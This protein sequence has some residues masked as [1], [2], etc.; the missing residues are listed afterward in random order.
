MCNMSEGIR[1]EALKEGIEIGTQKA[2]VETAIASFTAS[3]KGI[4]KAIKVDQEK[5]LDI[6]NVPE[7]YRAAVV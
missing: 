2:S 1:A 5:A 7:Q 3:V 4:I 6:A